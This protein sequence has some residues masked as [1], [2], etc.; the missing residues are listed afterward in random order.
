LKQGPFDKKYAKHFVNTFCVGDILVVAEADTPEVLL[1]QITSEPLVGTLDHL[2]LVRRTRQCTHTLTHPDCVQC[3][4]S[5]VAVYHTPDVKKE[6]LLQHLMEGH[7]A[8][9]FHSI[10][11]KVD[12][13]KSIDIREEK[14]SFHDYCKYIG[15]IKTTPYIIEMEARTE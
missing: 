13:L 1:V 14:E 15:S 5:I 9:P 10:Y 6:D 2:C 4:D 8:E 3:K 12:I 7:I 11:R